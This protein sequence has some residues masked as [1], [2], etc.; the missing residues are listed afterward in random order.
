ALL[1]ALLRQRLGKAVDAGLGSGVVDLA[2][3]PGLSVDGPDVDDAA[4]AA[5]DH[6]GKACFRHVEATAKV[7]AHDVVP[8]F[9]GHPGERAVA[10]DAGIVY[11]DVDRA[12]FFG[13]ARAAVEARLMVAHVPFIGPNA[14]A[15]GE[16]L[17]LFVVP[18]VVDDHRDA[19]GLKSQRDCF[20]DAAAA[21][22]DDC[23]TCHVCCSHMSASRHG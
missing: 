19:I 3:L 15:F 20:S 22:G 7:D 23:D 11:D 14:G 1:R 5:F 18:G 17:R 6:S 2:I 8:V 21:A 13:D 12:D 10:G 9:E 16:S 4:P